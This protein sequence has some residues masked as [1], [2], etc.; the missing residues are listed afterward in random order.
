MSQTTGDTDSSPGCQLGGGYLWVSLLKYHSFFSLAVLSSMPC[1]EPLLFIV[2][3]KER[4][5]HYWE[6]SFSL[7]QSYNNIFPS[8]R[9]CVSSW[10]L[11]SHQLGTPGGRGGPELPI[12]PQ[13]Q[14]VKA[15]LQSPQQWAGRGVKVSPT[16]REREAC[17]PIGDGLWVAVGEESQ[18]GAGSHVFPHTFFPHDFGSL[19]KQTFLMARPGRRN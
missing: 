12:T 15:H 16:V 2:S 8:A 6:I 17:S 18:R 10:L 4:Q 11:A 3:S 9:C 14:L 1:R 7:S 13:R 5:C 19:G